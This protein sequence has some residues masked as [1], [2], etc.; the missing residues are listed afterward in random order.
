MGNLVSLLRPAT[1]EEAVALVVFV[2]RDLNRRYPR[3]VGEAFS[4]GALDSAVA[5]L[6]S[7]GVRD[8]WART[9]ME[10]VI[11]TLLAVREYGL[12]WADVLV[13]VF[14]EEDVTPKFAPVAPVLRLVKG[15]AR[16]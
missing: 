2:L 6:V 13:G 16:V 12:T 10:N 11:Q 8:R 5:S 7:E 1:R 14:G 4:S 9:G 3:Y 15:G